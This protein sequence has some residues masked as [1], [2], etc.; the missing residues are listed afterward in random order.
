MTIRTNARIKADQGGRLPEIS[1]GEV[2]PLDQ[3][4]LPSISSE[5]ADS[6]A[7]QSPIKQQP[8]QVFAEQADVPEKVDFSY[9]AGKS[10]DLKQK[11]GEMVGS[12]MTQEAS[13]IAASLPQ[14]ASKVDQSIGAT[15]KDVSTNESVSDA[16]SADIANLSGKRK[17]K[18]KNKNE[19]TLDEATKPNEEQVK[20]RDQSKARERSVAFDPRT[21]SELSESGE[22]FT[23]EFTT[24]IP[25]RLT[26]KPETTQAPPIGE[27]Q[28]PPKQ[29]AESTEN[30]SNKYNRDYVEEEKDSRRNQGFDGNTSVGDMIVDSVVIP[31][32]LYTTGVEVSKDAV[33]YMSQRKL[34]I[35]ENVIAGLFER[36]EQKGKRKT[37]TKK[38]ID[39]KENESLEEQVVRERTNAKK[40]FKDQA[41]I[42]ERIVRLVRNPFVLKVAGTT[43]SAT[44]TGKGSYVVKAT[45]PAKAA[46]KY[47]E[48]KEKLNWDGSWLMQMIILHAGIGLDK[49]NLDKF[50]NGSF[51]GGKEGL[52][53]LYLTEDEMISI[54]DN[55]M[56]SMRLYGHP[57][58]NT[59]KTLKLRG[60]KCFP[61]GFLSKDIAQKIINRSANA[62]PDYQLA[63]QL[64]AEEMQDLVKK[65]WLN[66]TLPAL[67]SEGMTN[68]AQMWALYNMNLALLEE[69]G[70][71]A[72]SFGL[73]Y[74]KDCELYSIWYSMEEARAQGNAVLAQ[75]LQRTYENE[76]KIW[77]D[78]LKR[79]YR[80]QSY[81][82]SSGHTLS[83]QLAYK[84]NSVNRAF[85]T[86]AS[87]MRFNA[88]AFNPGVIISGE[89]DHAIGSKF[90]AR[91]G[92]FF[93]GTQVTKD[94]NYTVSKNLEEVCK[95]QEAK[96]VYEILVASVQNGG[97][98]LIKMYLETT[99]KPITKD[100][101]L[102]FLNKI[103]N[104]ALDSNVNMSEKE[105]NVIKRKA[106]DVARSITDKAMVGGLLFRDSDVLNFVQALMTNMSVSNSNG[107]PA[108]STD[109]IE[110]SIASRGIARSLLELAS[111]EPG[112]DAFI[113]S[114]NGTLGRVSP[115][116]YAISKWLRD[117][118]MA[119]FML[120]ALGLKFLR[121]NAAFIER[122][123]PA[124][125]TLSYMAVHFGTK[126]QEFAD[127]RNY[128]LGGWHLDGESVK[129]NP[130]FWQGLKECL[131]YDIAN[132]ATTAS[133]AALFY[134]IGLLISGDDDE[135]ENPQNK[136]VWTEWLAGWVPQ[137]WINDIV[138]WGA[139]LG[140][141]LAVL[142]K[143]P[144]QPEL[145]AGVLQ[146]GL[147]DMLDGNVIAEF[148]DFF[149]H[150]IDELEK[151]EQ[152]IA[153]GDYNAPPS[154]Q[155]YVAMLV[156]GKL[157]KFF[158]SFIPFSG[159][160]NTIYSS[161]STLLGL[162]TM[163][164][165]ANK[166]W[167][168]EDYTMEEAKEGDH[169]VSTTWEDRRRRS[170]SKN[171]FSYAIYNNITKNGTS[172]FDPL[173]GE[174]DTNTSYLAYE[175]PVQTAKDS[176]RLEFMSK[177]SFDPNDPEI[178]KMED[179]G[180]AI[181][182]QKAEELIRDM[183]SYG[184]PEN[185]VAQGGMIGYNERENAIDY[186]FAM[187]RNADEM[188]NEAEINY[189]I[190]MDSTHESG[191]Y[192]YLI[193]TYQYA[194]SDL[195][196]AI[197][198]ARLQVDQAWDIRNKTVSYYYDILDDW[199]QNEDIPWSDAGYELLKTDYSIR[200]KWVDTGEP[201]YAIDYWLN[202]DQVV[203]EYYRAG[204]VQSLVL[205][206]TPP[207]DLGNTGYDRQT[208][209][210]YYVE[211]LTDTQE[212]FN[213]DKDTTVEMGFNTGKDLNAVTFGGSNTT[214]GTDRE[215]AVSRNEAGK[216]E[217][218]RG[219]RNKPVSGLRAAIPHEKSLPDSLKNKTME[220]WLEENGLSDSDETS[221]DEKKE[222]TTTTK[223]P[224]YGSYRRSGGGG[225]NYSP[226]I[227]AHAANVSYDK[228]STM[229]AAKPY[230]QS[231][232]YIRPTYETKG[233]RKAYK[234]S[235]I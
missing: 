203:Q 201:A 220:D 222:T 163:E 50:P 80:E 12:N 71:D 109:T 154:K 72:S 28:T 152:A 127:V 84:N 210:N 124:S 55:I 185:F 16:V 74:M 52:K 4:S 26:Q 121:Y 10:Q 3:K 41:T 161:G 226:K 122:F 13:A 25:E 111:T 198:D 31:E 7:S 83:T 39:Q 199:L 231:T 120:C 51:W 61:V 45:M 175:M 223:Y 82:D 14:V 104:G 169:L 91:M 34:S 44:P 138:T 170:M 106:M 191:E 153:D 40:S 64:T 47:N 194:G 221:D 216:L 38:E 19:N 207:L 27:Q 184:S 57:L 165:S 53:D 188:K 93:Y 202:P 143:H 174:T 129:D 35:L 196:K 211:G 133:I 197:D 141:A 46:A 108:L 140:V 176:V 166:I 73:D 179:G 43:I 63:S 118:G 156:E 5:E 103:K 168:T 200:Y 132:F 60:T 149:V 224:S 182:A 189:D 37:K 11:L 92:N 1:T 49:S 36:R 229:S 213:R 54:I 22:P 97:R 183:L 123:I 69:A 230:K 67:R 68:P 225:T 160:I 76:K 162:N 142:T 144:E 187:I 23:A 227:Y 150:G 62:H 17:S 145:F 192:D 219:N 29:S 113:A 75:A 136:Y 131:A 164:H 119:D 18:S 100:N 171:M 89:I 79:Y 15:T 105:K 193:A 86:F 117:H 206:F 232:S 233:S 81:V 147:A 177:H 234:R 215:Y 126:G 65:E 159:A 95:T 214:P 99:K 146:S 48:A 30:V 2:K 20:V 167:N 151:Q 178:A 212:I 235:D 56:E 42:R 181:K 78:I 128:Q 32:N 172:I 208:V 9:D 217:D 114:T 186:C 85:N 101:F 158:D 173:H 59:G 24:E 70:E 155:S 130:E 6:L 134:I 218:E 204:N 209:S 116:T 115:L 135:P 107:K 148:L 66:V 98:I 125:N 110:R 90:T 112:Y 96:E 94:K 21:V 102:D 205:P 87:I 8:D 139:P 58:G 33:D 137:W 190:L 77:N 195:Q 180:A 228:A 88:V 157:A